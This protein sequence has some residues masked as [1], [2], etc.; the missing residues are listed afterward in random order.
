MI[1]AWIEQ[2]IADKDQEAEIEQA[3]NAKEEAELDQQ[4]DIAMGASLRDY[5]VPSSID[6]S[7][8]AQGDLEPTEWPLEHAQPE[9]NRSSEDDTHGFSG[10]IRHF[11]GAVTAEEREY[12][13]ERANQHEGNHCEICCSTQELMSQLELRQAQSRVVSNIEAEYLAI[14]A[15]AATQR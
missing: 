6:S 12:L 1:P 3:H 10:A 11:Q 4:W 7:F 5:R 8:V 14:C 13:A 2:W 9:L 15:Y